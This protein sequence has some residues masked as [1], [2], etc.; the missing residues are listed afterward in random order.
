MCVHISVNR[1]THTYPHL[2]THT[3]TCVYMCLYTYINK[4]LCI[5]THIYKHTY[6]YMYTH[7]YIWTNTHTH[8]HIYMYTFTHIHRPNPSHLLNVDIPAGSPGCQVLLPCSSSPAPLR[9]G[10]K[11]KGEKHKASSADGEQHRCLLPAFIC[12]GWDPHRDTVCRIKWP[13]VRRK[14]RRKRRKYFFLSPVRSRL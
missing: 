1:H 9:N 8:I 12:S 7:L 4:F 5:Y 13:P 10:L 2:Y 3:Y 14:V 6:V 11:E